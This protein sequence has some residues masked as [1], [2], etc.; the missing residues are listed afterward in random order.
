M[1]DHQIGMQ[2]LLQQ[3]HQQFAEG[4]GPNALCLQVGHPDM[5][6]RH[7]SARPWIIA[8]QIHPRYCLGRG[9]SNRRHPITSPNQLRSQMGKLA[10]KVLVK[11]QNVARHLPPSTGYSIITPMHNLVLQQHFK[12]L[13]GHIENFQS[14]RS[15]N[16]KNI[17]AAVVCP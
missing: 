9:G 8:M 17:A 15:R 1:A 13:S 5:T 14:H 11:K 6:G 2:T 12:T 16:A 3:L 10:R 4:L 7:P